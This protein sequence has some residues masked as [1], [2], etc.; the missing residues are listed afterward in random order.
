M[1]NTLP[2][3]QTNA[4]TVPETQGGS[5]LWWEIAAVAGPLLLYVL[6][7]LPL[8]DWIVDDAGISFA[9]ARNLAHGYG[10]VSQ[11][12]MTPVEGYS[13]FLWVILITP[14]FWLGLFDP[15]VTPKVLSLILI[16][17]SYWYAH[18]SMRLLTDG[19][20]L[21]SAIALTLLSLNTSFIVW[22]CSGLENPLT[23]LLVAI[24]TYLLISAVKFGEF[25]W[26]NGTLMGLTTAALALTR[27]DGIVYALVFPMAVGLAWL[28]PRLVSTKSII[29]STA[30]YAGTITVVLGSFLLFRFLYYGDLYPNTYYKKGGPHASDLVSL[31]TLQGG[32][33]TKLRD[34]LA[35][36][37]GAKLWLIVGIAF[38][39]WLVLVVQRRG[40][41]RL[42]AVLLATTGLAL[43]IHLLLLR[44]WMGENRFATAF[45]LLGYMSLTI[46][47]YRVFTQRLASHRRYPIAVVAVLVVAVGLT[48]YVNHRRLGDFYSHPVV[49]FAD[50]V[51]RYAD[52]FNAYAKYLGVE[53]G[54]V[55][56]PDLGGTLYYCNLTVYDLAGL[57]DP[58]IARTMGLNQKRDVHA[59][60][61]YVFDS[62]KPTFI[63]THGTFTGAA[64]FEDDPRFR[65]DYVP[66][67]EYKDTYVERV[68]KA[69]RMSGNFVRRD[70]I[71]GKEARLDSLQRGLAP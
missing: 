46:I 17:M 38:I 59:F 71:K 13:N 24:L 15:Y 62:L 3:G 18:K 26:R 4:R 29:R 36:F 43:I 44:D 68:Y 32:Y 61:D 1:R 52:K 34:V 28:P 7:T 9:Y 58:V 57:C 63:Q 70:A 12:G 56:L 50:V 39:V 53:D 49:P 21:P 8:F 51:E 16:A 11:P 42:D 55:L 69:S 65:E 31:L 25:D 30:G 54:S 19:S 33:I 2:T 60:H 23:V 45:F 35:A 22:T 6:L 14:F 37:F 27:P 5:R 64:R 10:L 66:I 47:G 20:I 48:V 67:H 41:W 40:R